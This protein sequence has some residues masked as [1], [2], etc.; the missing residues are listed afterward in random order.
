[1]IA[2]RIGIAKPTEFFHSKTLYFL[3]SRECPT[4]SANVAGTLLCERKKKKI[5]KRISLA[6]SISHSTYCPTRIKRVPPSV[7][8]MFDER[9]PM[10]RRSSQ[11]DTTKK[12]ESFN[13]F[14]VIPVCALS[15]TLVRL[16][17]EPNYVTVLS[18][19]L[20]LPSSKSTFSQPS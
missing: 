2:P 1:M 16:K 8:H 9:E 13:V 12:P 20:P 7:S 17:T 19:T 10:G 11:W 6:R 3:P 14:P 5:K 4:S 15:C 18:F